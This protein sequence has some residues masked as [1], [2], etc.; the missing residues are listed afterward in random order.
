MSMYVNVSCYLTS[1][2]NTHK[3][4]TSTHIQILILLTIIMMVYPCENLQYDRYH[5]R[6]L[7]EPVTHSLC[8]KK[9]TALITTE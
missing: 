9:F 7:M 2:Y 5:R 8:N 3:K 6:K 1:I 4:Y